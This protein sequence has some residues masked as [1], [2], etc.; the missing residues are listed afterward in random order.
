VRPTRLVLALV[1]ALAGLVWLGQGL[2]FI[3]GSFMTGSLFWAVVGAGL[4]VL[5]V[6]IVAAERRRAA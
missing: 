6:V 4:I 2:G 3:P 5:A 1:F